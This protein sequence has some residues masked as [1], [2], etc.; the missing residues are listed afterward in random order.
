MAEWADMGIERAVP[1]LLLLSFIDG[2]ELLKELGVGS[3]SLAGVPHLGQLLDE[4]ADIRA[5]FERAAFFESGAFAGQ[6]FALGNKD[7][8]WAHGFA[9]SWTV[10]HHIIQ[11]DT[12]G[13]LDEK[14]I[15]I[16]TRYNILTECKFF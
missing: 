1:Q 14:I 5:D 11:S 4:L 8:I 6:T 13:S 9:K 7:S 3:F 12:H 10:E 16:K 15:I 2:I